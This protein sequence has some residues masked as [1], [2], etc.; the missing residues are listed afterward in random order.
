MTSDL[1]VRLRRY[2]EQLD[3]RVP[4]IEDLVASLEL[5]SHPGHRAAPDQ[6]RWSLQ[7]ALVV[8]TVAVA[9]LLLVGGAALLVRSAGSQSPVATTQEPLSLSARSWARAPHDE[10]VFGGPGRQR[11]FSVISGETG[12]VAVGSDQPAADLDAAVWTSSDGIRWSRAPHDEFVL[13]GSD[14]QEMYSV[15]ATS[16]GFVAVGFDGSGGDA[17]AAAWTSS[18]GRTWSRVRHDEAVFGGVGTQEMW[19]VAANGAQLVAV[20]LDR[21]GSEADA[22]VWTST[23]GLNWSRVPHDEA[24]LGGA[25]F[26]EMFSVTAG[27]PGW[28]AGGHHRIGDDH[29]AAAWSSPDGIAW[30]RVPHDAALFGGPAADED[31]AVVTQGGPGLVAVG[32]ERADGI[33][34]AAVWISPD[35]FTW[36]RVPHDDALF[37]GAEMRSVTSAGGSAVIAVGHAAQG[38]G[39]DAAVWTSIDGKNWSRML[40]QDGVFGG[41]GHQEM[42]SATTAG[43]DLVAV[44]S[45]RRTGPPDGAAWVARQR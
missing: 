42:W 3:S 5:E 44:G 20:G 36:S 43:S 17:D 35:G 30:Q 14:D 19:A 34:K 9:V 40:D 45:S 4:P 41:P 25:G 15:A 18:D 26:V 29:N 24:A 22:A 38:E 16:W 28:V 1:D 8:A 7:P 37:G 10:A 13:G 27:G 2:G 33:F 12:L 32:S 11:L 39:L 21:H 6:P 31:I 23:D